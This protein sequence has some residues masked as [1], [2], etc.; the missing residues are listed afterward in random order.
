[1]RARPQNTK[2]FYLGPISTN[3]SEVGNFEEEITV[4][5]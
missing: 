3:L 5:N 1:M 2:S 4:L